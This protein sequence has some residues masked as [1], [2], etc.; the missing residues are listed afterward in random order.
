[1]IIGYV[2]EQATFVTEPEITSKIFSSQKVKIVG[3]FK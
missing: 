2:I 3:L 1:M